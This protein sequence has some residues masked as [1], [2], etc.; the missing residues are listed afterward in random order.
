MRITS[1]ILRNRRFDVPSQEVRPTKESVR[2]AIF[3]SLGGRCEGWRVLDL[4]A[5]AGSLGLEA[6][7]RGAVEVVLVEQH[8]QVF[9]TLRRNVD[10]LDGPQLGKITCLRGDAI[11]YLERADGIFDLILADPPY[12]LPGAMALTLDGITRHSVLTPGG[13]VVYELRAADPV[14]PVDGW[15]VLRDKTYGKTRV[16]MLRRSGEDE[17]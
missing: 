3:S 1:G 17:A 9:R 7:S 6:W 14:E 16:L 13:T 8:P 11:R 10:G 15:T 4:F 12:D 2:E 5:G